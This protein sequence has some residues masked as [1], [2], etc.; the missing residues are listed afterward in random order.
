MGGGPQLSPHAQ[1]LI[2]EKEKGFILLCFVVLGLLSLEAP[3]S[4]KFD[5]W[6]F[7]GH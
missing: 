1:V 3:L 6:Q 7:K 2:K 5:K 4:R